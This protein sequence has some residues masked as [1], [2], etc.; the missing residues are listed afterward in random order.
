MVIK[1]LPIDKN[2]SSKF[3]MNLSSQKLF[4]DLDKKI[5][6]SKV[7]YYGL[8]IFEEIFLVKHHFSLVFLYKISQRKI[9]TN[10]KP[11]VKG[12]CMHRNLWFL[13]NLIISLSS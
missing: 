12:W 10:N 3:E 11:I 13:I 8:G 6:F 2:H 4:Q 7:E 1:G 9:Q 5:I